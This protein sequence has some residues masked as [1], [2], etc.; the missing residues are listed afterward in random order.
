MSAVMI[1]HRAQ[2]LAPEET[3]VAARARDFMM[4]GDQNIVQDA[5][6]WCSNRCAASER[7]NTGLI[8]F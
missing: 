6:S 4:R 2:L 8:L 7:R 5:V 1:H 3:T